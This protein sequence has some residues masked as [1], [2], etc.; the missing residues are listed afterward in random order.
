MGIVR[1]EVVDCLSGLSLFDLDLLRGLL[2]I[3]KCHF[4]QSKRFVVVSPHV[5]D[6]DLSKTV[7]V[8]RKVLQF[9]VLFV[10]IKRQYRNSIA[11]V[12]GET[13]SVVIYDKHVLN[14]SIF[15]DS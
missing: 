5:I 2:H 1:V 11:D 9:L 10:I 15:D 3:L 7:K 12:E 14:L 4:H 6:M 8:V 13:Q